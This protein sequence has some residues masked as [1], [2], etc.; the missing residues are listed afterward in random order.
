M[1]NIVALHYSE[2]QNSA[3]IIQPEIGVFTNIGDAHSSGF[4]DIQTKIEEKLKLF[5]KC[6]TIVLVK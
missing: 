3:Q 6:K 4:K 5:E 2:M 1:G